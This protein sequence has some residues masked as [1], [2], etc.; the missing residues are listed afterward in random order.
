MKVTPEQLEEWKRISE[1]FGA[2]LDRG[3]QVE[4]VIHAARYAMPALIEA[5]EKLREAS[6]KAIEHLEN[7]GAYQIACIKLK[8]ALGEKND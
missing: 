1:D 5:V 6:Y 4:G 7:K 8:K 2:L 3:K